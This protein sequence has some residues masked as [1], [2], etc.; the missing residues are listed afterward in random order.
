MLS[1]VNLDTGFLLTLVELKH[2][3]EHLHEAD[4]KSF[5]YLDALRLF[6]KPFGEQYLHQME[7]F[8]KSSEYR[9]SLIHI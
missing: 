6:H 2:Q 9:L 5:Y 4:S 8:A 3:K 7:L 1:T